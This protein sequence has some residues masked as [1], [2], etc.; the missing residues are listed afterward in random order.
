MISQCYASGMHVGHEL[1]YE[2]AGSQGKRMRLDVLHLQQSP[3]DRSCGLTC[4]LMAAMLVSGLPR[5]YATSVAW[6]NRRELKKLWAVARVGYFRGTAPASIARYLNIVCKGTKAIA[7]TGLPRELFAAVVEGLERDNV[8]LV[9]IGASEKSQLHWVLVTGVEYETRRR[10]SETNQRGRD[11]P[12]A[13]LGLDPESPAPIC[14]AFNWRLPRRRGKKGR[15]V[16]TATT[17][18]S[19][20]D[21]ALQRAVTVQRQI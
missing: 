2:V 1:L 11:V 4:V 16:S 14:S 18:G 20:D 17:A 13:L 12:I 5:D 15:H 6:T 19:S 8:S 21:R 7:V 10:S 3:L 9:L